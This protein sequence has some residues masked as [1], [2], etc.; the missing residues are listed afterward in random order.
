MIYEI[1]DTNK[2]K[3]IF[4]GWHETLIYSCLQKVMGKIYVT[5]L[6]NPRSAFTTY[7]DLSNRFN[8]FHSFNHDFCCG[9]SNYFLPSFF[10]N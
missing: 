10:S 7:S 4:D 1:D 8:D 3:D 5:D 9:T 6:D 2:V